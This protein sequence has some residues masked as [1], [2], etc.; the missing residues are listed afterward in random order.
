MLVWRRTHK[1]NAGP[2]LKPSGRIWSGPAAHQGELRTRSRLCAGRTWRE[3]NI[4]GSG[5]TTKRLPGL[6][7]S[8]TYFTARCI[9]LRAGQ[10]ARLKSFASDHVL[11]RLMRALTKVLAVA[12]VI[13]VLL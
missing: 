8:T 2:L 13:V 5:E 3:P 12:S 4:D 11:S 7:G 10:R 6:R 9:R 1:T